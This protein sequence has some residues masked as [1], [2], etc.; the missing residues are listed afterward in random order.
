[1]DSTLHVLSLHPDWS[2]FLPS[3]AIR[4][5]AGQSLNFIRHAS[6]ASHGS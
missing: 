4:K 5:A 3:A 2:S 6:L 1:M